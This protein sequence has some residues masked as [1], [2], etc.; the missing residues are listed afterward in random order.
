MK[1]SEPIAIIGQGCVL[2]GCFSPQDLWQMVCSNQV[3]IRAAGARDWRVDMDQVL[4]EPDAASLADKAWNSQGGYIN[5]F[6]QHFDPASFELD[7]NLVAGL[8]PVF[9]WSFYAAQAA[10]KDAGYGGHADRERTGLIL[11]NLSYPTRAFSRYFEEQHL[12]ALFPEWKNPH[13]PADAAN[14]FM[15]GLPAMLTARALGLQGEA[16]AIDAA[17]AS[18]LYALK[19]GI[20]QLQAGT[21]DM[22]LV[23]GVCAADQLF[24]HVGFTALKALSP[25][26]QSRPFNQGADGLIPSEGAGFVVIKRLS[27]AVRHQDRILGVVRGLG[28][29]NDGR[30]GGFLSPAQSGQVQSMKKALAQAGLPPEALTYIECHATGTAGGDSV[31]IR[32]LQEVYGQ[33]PALHLSS[34]K[35]NIGHAITA[36]GIGSIIKVLAAFRE[37]V[38]P[39]SP[40][41]YPLNALLSETRFT[42]SEAPQAWESPGNRVAGISNFGFGGNNAHVILEE[43][44]PQSSYPVRQEA[45]VPAR[46]AIVGLELQSEQFPDAQA[47]L[48]RLLGWPAGQELREELAFDAGKLSSPPSDLKYALSQQLLMLHTTQRLLAK[49]IRL[50]PEKT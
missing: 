36:S 16:F 44:D 50:S 21:A 3:H 40:Q 12:Q 4:A 27:D 11:G 29:S 23:G 31:E 6:E 48:N 35:G 32:S 18:S 41:A 24:L 42:V 8:D 10:L 45:A 26:G 38:L 5:G 33:A 39:P 19:L 14:R 46:V 43:W 20:D 30:A 37:R 9:Q 49:G 25:T 22:M 7:P 28:L 1:E 17:C 13:T 47:Y 15:S 2:P 34:L